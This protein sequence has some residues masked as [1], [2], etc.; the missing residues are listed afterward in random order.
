MKLITVTIDGQT[1]AKVQDGKPLYEND[2][3]QHVPFDAVHSLN[4]I[5]QLNGEAKGHREE[6]EKAQA[7][8]KKFAG[9]EDPAAALK[10]LETIANID[11]S[12]LV[13]AGKVEEIKAAAAKAAEERTQAA[14][15]AKD[16]EYAPILQERDSLKTAL[17]A[18]LVGG[19]FARSQFIRDKM[20][21]HPDEVQALF[22]KN[23]KVEDNKLVPYDNDGRPIYSVGK[24]GDIAGLD[25]AL[26]ILVSRHPYRDDMLKSGHKPGGGA[27]HSGGGG[28]GKGTISRSQFDAMSQ[29]E[30]MET[31]RNGVKIVD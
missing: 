21:R 14:I 27:Q 3:G 24:P 23:I 16:E 9:I 4:K 31:A 19:G 26:E 18:E 22:G 1:Y 13:E 8:L 29:S 10:A 15:A 17:H 7:D 2:E 25:E 6:K 30:R 28:G 20:A 12:K 11:A 5:S